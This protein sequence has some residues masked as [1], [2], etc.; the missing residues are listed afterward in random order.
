[1][2]DKPTYE[3]SKNQMAGLK[4]QDEILRLALNS[5]KNSDNKQAMKASDEKYRFDSAHVTMFI[6]NKE[7]NPEVNPLTCE[8]P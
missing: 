7:R 3:E 1:M 2:N 8:S 4:K 6:H 5:D